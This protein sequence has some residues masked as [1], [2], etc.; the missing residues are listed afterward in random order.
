[1]RPAETFRRL[2]GAWRN[3]FKELSAF[4]V[5]GGVSFLIDIGLFQ[6][7]YAWVG[8]GAVTAKLLATLVSMTVAYVGHRY[9]SFSHRSRPGVRKEY[10]RFTLINGATLLLGLVVVGFVRHGLDQ[11]SALVL[12]V[13]NV[14]SIVVGTLIRYLSYRRWVFPV[15]TL[16]ADDATTDGAHRP[17]VR[18]RHQRRESA[19]QAGALAAGDH[20]EPAGDTGP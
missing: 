13:A 6:V 14:G 16:A 8:L 10:V 2:R 19:G 11:Q 9:W 20:L 17:S 15:R 12:Q 7:L 3:L 5:V 4:G 1:V 18:Q